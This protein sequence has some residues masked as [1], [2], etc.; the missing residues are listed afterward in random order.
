[1]KRKEN[2]DQLTFFDV[3][4]N[5]PKILYY[6]G[7]V[8]FQQLKGEVVPYTITGENW[9]FHE[10]KNRGYRLQQENGCYNV[11]TN[12]STDFYRTQKEAEEA[13]G[14]WLSGKDVISPEQIAFTYIEAYQYVRNLEG[15]YKMTAFLGVLENGNLYIKNFTSFHHIVKDSKKARKSFQEDIERNTNCK[16]EK[17]ED[18]TPE[19]KRMYRCKA[20]DTWMYAE[21][22]YGGTIG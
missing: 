11:V 19:V 18:Y 12:D 15:D 6:K 16:I 13:A 1:M 3:L 17:I 10:N 21:A 9:L 2:K 4:N 7:D 5:E 14:K 20:G 22:R 8:L